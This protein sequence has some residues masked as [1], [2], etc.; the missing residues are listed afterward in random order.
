MPRRLVLYHEPSRR[1][2]NSHIR[3]SGGGALL[4]SFLRHHAGSIFCYLTAHDVS[5]RKVLIIAPCS[6]PAA[7]CLLVSSLF[8]LTGMT[9]FSSID[10]FQSGR[11]RWSTDVLIKENR[12]QMPQSLRATT[13]F[14]ESAS[15]LVQRQ[16]GRRPARGTRRDTVRRVLMHTSSQ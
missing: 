7:L 5:E 13:L 1:S 12:V 16:E 2:R 3:G 11:L 4:S 8:A 14:S 6:G 10:P 9:M 15:G